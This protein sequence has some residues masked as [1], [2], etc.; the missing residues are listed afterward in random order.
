MGERPVVVVSACLLGVP[1][2]HRG[3]GRVDPA[4]AALAATA[5][6]I[7]VCPEVAG[8]L[9]TPRPA[10]ER[11][12]DGRVRT[13]AG[14][15]VTDLYQRGAAQAV[16]LARATG[17]TRA[18]LKARSPS[19]GSSEIYDGS[20]R[21]MLVAGQGVTAEALRRHGVVVISEEQL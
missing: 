4:V 3:L 21:G 10:A 17:A 9:P 20:Y 16:E 5:R 11:G 7:P 2:N 6:L 14:E 13:A 1:C 8:G 18:V 12:P 19:C 15:D